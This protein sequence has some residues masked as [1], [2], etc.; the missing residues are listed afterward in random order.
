MNEASLEHAGAETQRARFSVK[1]RLGLAGRCSA[2]PARLGD[3]EPG[4]TVGRNRLAPSYAVGIGLAGEHLTIVIIADDEQPRFE[5]D[6]AVVTD[7]EPILPGQAFDG[8]DGACERIR[9]R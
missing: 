8:S 5:A 2:Q 1:V 6:S 9:M 4:F 3:D 7:E